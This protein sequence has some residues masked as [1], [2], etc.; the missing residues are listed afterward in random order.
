MSYQRHEKHLYTSNK[1]EIIMKKRRERHK[2]AL[3][4]A[5]REWINF[6]IIIVQ[7]RDSPIPQKKKKLFDIHV[8]STDYDC[9]ISHQPSPIYHHI[10]QVDFFFFLFWSRKSNLLF[11][12]SLIVRTK[13]KKSMMSATRDFHH[14]HHAYLKM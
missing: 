10:V 8:L 13:K 5:L 4:T 12:L 3:A 9:L 6:R 2:L 1:N 11:V 14:Q 7:N